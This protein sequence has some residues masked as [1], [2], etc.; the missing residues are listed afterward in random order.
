MVPFASVLLLSYS[1]RASEDTH[2]SS[3]QRDQFH[4]CQS[5]ANS[6]T[7]TLPT[8]QN[9]CSNPLQGCQQSQILCLS[10]DWW[11]YKVIWVQVKRSRKQSA[12]MIWFAVKTKADRQCIFVISGQGHRP[13]LIC[14]ALQAEGAVCPLADGSSRRQLEQAATSQLLW[15]WGKEAVRLGVGSFKVRWVI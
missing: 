2:T 10:A 5:A 9:N 7:L 3:H 1:R 15:V 13:A 11:R 14:L 6:F 4:W 8:W 12:N